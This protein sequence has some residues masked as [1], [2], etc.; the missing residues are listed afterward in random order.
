MKLVSATVP[1]HRLESVRRGLLAIGV[2][3]MTIGEVRCDDVDEPMFRIETAVPAAA[4]DEV[5]AA[6]R[7]RAPEAATLGIVAFALESVTRVRTGEFD[8]YAV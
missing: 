5:V 3:G 2:G 8:E 4:V 7:E 1:E 6:I